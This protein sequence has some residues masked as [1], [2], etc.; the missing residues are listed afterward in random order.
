MVHIVGI[1]N[2]NVVGLLSLDAV[3]ALQHQYSEE[4][5]DIRTRQKVLQY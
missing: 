4:L 3:D 1:A 2:E 5:R